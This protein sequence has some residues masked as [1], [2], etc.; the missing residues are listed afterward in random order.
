MIDEQKCTTSLKSIVKGLEQ[1]LRKS[2][3]EIESLTFRNQQLVKRISCLQND[4]QIPQAHS[5]YT[6][7]ANY[8]VDSLIDQKLIENAELSALVWFKPLNYAKTFFNIELLS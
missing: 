2:N 8:C 5:Y 4:L 3:Q 6:N 7:G 1:Q